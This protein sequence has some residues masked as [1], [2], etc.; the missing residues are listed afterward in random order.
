V[1][2]EMSN[3]I[4]FVVGILVG[5]LALYTATKAVRGRK[6]KEEPGQAQQDGAAENQP[7][8]EIIESEAA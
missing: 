1:T 6:G 5:A 8:R 2:A 7:A 4:L 3:A